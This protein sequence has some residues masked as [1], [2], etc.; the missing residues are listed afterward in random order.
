MSKVVKLKKGLNLKV[1]GSPA[2]QLV[3]LISD[4]Y[5]IKPTDFIGFKKPKVLVKPGDKVKAGSQLYFD[6]DLPE[7]RYTSPVS[8]E[9]VEVKR[10]A[11][12]KLLEIVVKA[13]GLN[14]YEDFKAYSVSEL[15]ALSVEDTKQQ[16]LDSGLWSNIIQRPYAV[17]AKPAVAP[18]S[19]FI[20]CFDSSPL[21]PDYNFTLKGEE[22]NFS[23][24]VDVLKKFCSLIQLA[25]MLQ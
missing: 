13:D 14:E 23:T 1:K 9:V 6:K 16:I 10:G 11:Q 25:S 15:D 8:G 4:T 7:V 12:R 3:E 19:I 5:A 21:A 18:R 24:G 17:V 20:S 22:K 2:E